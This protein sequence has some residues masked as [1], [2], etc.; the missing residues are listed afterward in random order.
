MARLMWLTSVVLS[1]SVADSKFAQAALAAHKARS[2]QGSG[3]VTARLVQ[4]GKLRGAA[5][6]SLLQTVGQVSL[7]AGDVSATAAYE[8]NPEEQLEDWEDGGLAAETSFTDKQLDELDTHITAEAYGKQLHDIADITPSR[9]ISTQGNVEAA[10]HMREEFDKLGLKVWTEDLVRSSDVAA[11]M[12]ASTKRSSAIIARLDGSDLSD[13]AIM[14]AAHFDSVNWEN[15]DMDAPGVDDNASGLALVMLLAKTLASR[16]VPLRRSVLF[17][18]FNAEE[19]G[20][21]GST[22]VAPLIASGKFG[23][24]KSV[25][26]ADEVAWPGS[27]SSA[28]HAIFETLGTVKG[29]TGLLDTFAHSLK[30]G[31]G[32]EGFK[33]NKHGFGSDHM[34][35]LEK[36]IPTVL[37]IE[38]DNM[39]HADVWGHSARDTF[40]HVDFDFGA[41]MSRLALRVVAELASPK[42]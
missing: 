18:A 38:G 29:T 22:Q 19:E 40:D 16:S 31:D 12:G 33:V 21:V 20:L 37:L 11:F 10:D 17:V 2:P 26:I 27:G 24:V 28:K 41:S 25:V 1:F 15:I 5:E 3:R 23:D 7:S 42:E 30:K 14:V 9:F 32:V 13:E 39:H 35:F 8:A 34:P 6:V 36:G 4:K